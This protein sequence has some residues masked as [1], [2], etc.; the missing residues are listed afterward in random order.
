MQ[1]RNV[2]IEMLRKVDS[3]DIPSCD[4]M[5][6]IYFIWG[7]VIGLRMVSLVIRKILKDRESKISEKFKGITKNLMRCT[8][9]ILL[10]DTFMV[11]IKSIQSGVSQ[12]L[13][14]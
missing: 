6:G 10:L 8:F 5:G 9:D 14:L 3:I 4:F 12:N 1:V 11:S 2:Y 13:N 7:I